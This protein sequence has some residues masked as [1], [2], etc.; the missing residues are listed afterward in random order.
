MK[1]LVV[2]VGKVRASYLREGCEDYIRRIRKLTP[3]EVKEVKVGKGNDGESI[4]KSEDE[5]IFSVLES[6][7]FK[8]AVLNGRGETLSSERFAR[9][10]KE[11]ESSGSNGLSFVIGGAWGLG[12]KVLEKAAFRWSMGPMTMSHELAR[13]VLFEQIYRAETTLRGIPY[14]K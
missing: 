14:P 12:Q 2:A 5:R 7:A 10:L 8:T 6:V 1:I 4:K 9:L 3:I 11:L 13:L